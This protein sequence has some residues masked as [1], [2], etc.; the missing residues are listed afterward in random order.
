M[1]TLF[2]FLSLAALGCHKSGASQCQ[3]CTSYIIGPDGQG[4]VEKD[5]LYTGQKYCGQQL[6]NA[7][8]EHGKYSQV[9][10]SRWTVVVSCQ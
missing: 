2:L 10:G 8:A 4:G 9:G 6:K 5:T 1:K 3:T 7:Q